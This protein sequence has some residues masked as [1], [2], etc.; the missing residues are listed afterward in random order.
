MSSCST[1]AC[2]VPYDIWKESR[3]RRLLVTQAKAAAI[4]GISGEGGAFQIIRG[5]FTIC[6]RIYNS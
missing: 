4:G 5:N 6:E 2:A 1:N 3:S